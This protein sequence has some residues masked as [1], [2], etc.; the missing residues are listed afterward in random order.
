MR[1]GKKGSLDVLDMRL[2]S[3]RTGRSRKKV[4]V[5]ASS[6]GLGIATILLG[7][8]TIWILSMNAFFHGG[9]TP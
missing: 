2:G 7:I 8:A 1:W 3:P 9:M 6:I 4:V 5:M